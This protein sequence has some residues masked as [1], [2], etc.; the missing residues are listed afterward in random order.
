[1]GGVSYAL[2]ALAEE[3]DI[4]TPGAVTTWLTASAAIPLV[5]VL[6]TLLVAAFSPEP[7]Q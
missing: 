5:Q 7:Q 4:F 6:W 3:K 1:M 2:D